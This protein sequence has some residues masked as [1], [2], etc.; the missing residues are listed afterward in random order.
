MDGIGAYA[1]RLG[2]GATVQPARGLPC[3]LAVSYSATPVTHSLRR[4]DN[5]SWCP[6]GAG[7][8]PLGS[9]SDARLLIMRLNETYTDY[10]DRALAEISY[11]QV[12][13]CT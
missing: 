9:A 6:A 5:G 12:D 13:S 2:R 11:R 7:S 10:G 4:D 1:R 3:A 8:R